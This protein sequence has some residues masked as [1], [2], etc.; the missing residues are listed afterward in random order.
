MAEREFPDLRP[1][2]R[3]YSPGTYPQNEFRA[4]NGATTV[5]RYGN[6]RVNSELSLSFENISDSDVTQILHNYEQVNA[7]WHWIRFKDRDAAVGTTTE[8]G[9]FI[10]EI[11]GSGLR[12]RYAEPPTV[13]SVMRGI[14]NV[15][16]RFTAYL[17]GA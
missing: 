6:R 3:S 14:S 2:G 4:Q 1:T 15:E 12:W 11:G 9:Q 16:C 17:D 7:G 13:T 5:V 8:L 10:K